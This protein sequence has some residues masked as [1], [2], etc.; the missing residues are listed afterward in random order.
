MDDLELRPRLLYAL[1]HFAGP[2]ESGANSPRTSLRC[3]G[4]AVAMF[5]F[6]DSTLLSLF[7]QEQNMS[8]DYADLLL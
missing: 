7:R 4:A 3:F 6:L 2:T 8:L 1:I 5:L